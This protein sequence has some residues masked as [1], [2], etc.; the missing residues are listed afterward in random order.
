M[1]PET[2]GIVLILLPG[3]EVE[4]GD[5]ESGRYRVTLAPF[6]AAEHELTQGQW[7]RI[8][9]TNPSRYQTGHEL[10]RSD[11][12]RHPVERVNWMECYAALRVLGLELPTEAQWEYAARGGTT[13]PWWT[14]ADPGDANVLDAAA[15]RQALDVLDRSRADLAIDDGHPAH[16]PVDAFDPNP[17]GLRAVHGNVWEWC[18][19]GYFDYAHSTARDGDG[20]RGADLPWQ[21][22]IFRGGSFAYPASASRSSVRAH[23]RP[24]ISRDDIGVRPVLNLPGPR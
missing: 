2:E 4:L 7:D 9:G 10:V 19:E 5:E 8:F 24:D 20:C 17:F 6:L 23:L 12:S 21:D 13:G 1:V 15:H 14:G 16:G 18:M 3:G 11:A 22:R